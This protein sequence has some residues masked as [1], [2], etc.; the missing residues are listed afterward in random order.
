MP[1]FTPS[2]ASA[3]CSRG[4]TRSHTILSPV[5]RLR[6]YPVIPASSRPYLTA[7]D[8][9]DPPPSP[10]VPPPIC[11]PKFSRFH[12]SHRI[13]TPP[14]YSP[15]R[16]PYSPV[17]PSPRT[18][19]TPSPRVSPLVPVIMCPDRPELS[20]VAPS[21]PPLSSLRA[22]SKGAHEIR[23]E[24]RPETIP[25]PPFPQVS[26]C[27][28]DRVK[29]LLPASHCGHV[30]TPSRM[31]NGLRVVRIRCYPNGHPR[32]PAAQVKKPR[33][34]RCPD[35]AEAKPVVAGPSANKQPERQIAISPIVESRPP[36]RVTPSPVAETASDPFITKSPIVHTPSK[37]LHIHSN[38]PRLDGPHTPF[39]NPDLNDQPLHWSPHM[40][41]PEIDSHNWTWSDWDSPSRE[42]I[43]ATY[44]TEDWPVPKSMAQFAHFPPDLRRRIQEAL[45]AKPTT[46]PPP[47][48]STDGVSA[49]TV[50]YEQVDIA[51][52]FA[53]HESTSSESG[54]I[55][56]LLQLYIDS[57]NDRQRC[58]AE[59]RD[60]RSGSSST[61]PAPH[62]D[63][64][65][66]SQSPGPSSKIAPKMQEV[67]ALFK[68]PQ[69]E[70]SYSSCSDSSL[71]FIDPKKLLNAAPSSVNSAHTLSTSKPVAPIPS[72]SSGFS[73]WVHV[74]YPKP[75]DDTCE[76]ALREAFKDI[77]GDFDMS[78]LCHYR[79]DGST[80]SQSVGTPAAA[81][82]QHFRALRQL[83]SAIVAEQ[84]RPAQE[85]ATASGF[86]WKSLACVAVAAATVGAG[87]AY[88]W[89]SG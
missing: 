66:R 60:T 30:V 22:L 56:S 79:R 25:E 34:S 61:S 75:S 27:P 18:P 1:L 63:T 43:N 7:L 28:C 67:F 58:N 2:K 4:L 52:S 50:R 3:A 33:Q 85:S 14:P 8:A 10:Y 20:R 57:D 23:W 73:S 42:I 76:R 6:P 48:L 88:A 15:I 74:D 45:G 44:Q 68:Q 39:K 72:E 19:S 24:S 82:H 26:P 84:Q 40:F 9:I 55:S 62:R 78:A 64:S 59:K 32:R 38:G 49:D 13:N 65:A 53:S 70:E 29:M 71:S 5:P 47:T 36:K 11:T 31:R 12:P 51:E 35:Q 83:P 69:K 86:G 37:P 80:A 46:P 21:A 87:L 41:Q 17:G 89:F 16:T 81:A 54:G 77:S